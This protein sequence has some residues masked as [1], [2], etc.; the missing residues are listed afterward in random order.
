M[1]GMPYNKRLY[2][3]G[4]KAGLPVVPIATATL[5]VPAGALAR[6]LFRKKL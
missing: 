4:H 2:R 3:V 5:T 1:T 6:F